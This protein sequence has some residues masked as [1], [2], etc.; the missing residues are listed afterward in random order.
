MRLYSPMPVSWWIQ[1]QVPPDVGP[2]ALTFDL[3]VDGRTC[4]QGRVALELPVALENAGELRLS[5]FMLTDEPL[6]V[7]EAGP[8]L[9]AENGGG[10]A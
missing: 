9:E 6:S 5:N 1:R 10:G 8:P 4:G 7:G 3:Q 2:L